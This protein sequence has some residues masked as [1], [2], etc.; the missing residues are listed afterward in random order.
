MVKNR[1]KQYA[2]KKGIFLRFCLHILVNLRGWLC[3]FSWYVSAV[4]TFYVLLSRNIRKNFLPLTLVSVCRQWPTFLCGGTLCWVTA[5]CNY[6]VCRSY[7]V[8][9]QLLERLQA[10]GEPR[11]QPGADDTAAWQ[12]TGETRILEGLSLGARISETTTVWHRAYNVSITQIG[13]STQSFQICW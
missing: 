1:G 2:R 10:H 9:R 6:A 12:R 4:C 3:F 11:C 8:S 7:Q 5:R 13:F